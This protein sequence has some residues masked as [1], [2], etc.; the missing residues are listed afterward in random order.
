MSMKRNDLSEFAVELLENDIAA[1]IIIAEHYLRRKGSQSIAYGLVHKTSRR[2]MGV[3]TYGT[4]LGPALR[5][6]VCGPDEHLNVIE[7]TR[8]W[9]HDDMPKNSASLL[10]G[11]TL[12]LLDKQIVVSYADASQGH[13]GRVYQATNWLYTGLSAEF[14]DTII[15]G[16]EHL[17]SISITDSGGGRGS[18]GSRDERLRTIYGDRVKKVERARKHRYITFTGGTRVKRVLRKKLR[19]ETKPYPKSTMPSVR[20][21]ENTEDKYYAKQPFDRW[22]N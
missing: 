21:V 15:E 4:P 9:V 22:F 10:I 2:I 7:L 8:L 19:Y 14:I 11:R 16:K 6:G 18:G 1:R 17:H 12:P 13:V 5:R 3:I 20:T